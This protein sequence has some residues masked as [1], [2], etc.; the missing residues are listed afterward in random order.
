MKTITLTILSLLLT[1]SA[2]SSPDK[3]QLKLRITAPGG[4]LDETTVYFDLGVSKFYIAP[5]DGPKVFSNLSNTPSI[6][7]ISSDNVFCSTNGYSELSASEI[8]PLGFTTDTAGEHI[9]SLSMLSNFNPTTMVRLEDRQL[10]VFTDLRMNAYTILLAD[11]TDDSNR[12]F[13]HVSRAVQFTPV[14]A[15]CTNNDGELQID[16]DNTIIWNAL[17]L[18]D[19][20]SHLIDSA[21]VVSGT[22]SFGGLAEGDYII[23]LALEENAVNMPIHINGTYVAATI[24]PSAFTAAVNE[25]ITF[26]S[27]EHNVVTYLW[28]FGDDTQYGGVANP[29]YAYV[30]PGIYK[31]TLTVSNDEGCKSKDSVQVT[32]TEF[33]AVNTI[34]EKKPRI[35]ANAKTVTLAL[36]DKVTDGTALSIYNLLGQPVYTQAI[37]DLTTVVM[38]NN[39]TEGYYMVALQ[40]DGKTTSTKRVYISR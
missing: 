13:L 1:Y 5:E 17:Y 21:A 3:K 29:A 32:I 2:F 7:S 38:L 27:T 24:H 40:Q 18:Y 16:G 20:T 12:F 25:E 8:I 30:V 35:W 23:I 6:Y 11:S 10:G 15:G 39:A 31:V 26:Q 33:S 34:Q 36:N 9:F 28:D 37:T 19:S 14:T 22:Y 4:D